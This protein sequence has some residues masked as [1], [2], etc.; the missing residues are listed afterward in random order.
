MHRLILSTLVAGTLLAVHMPAA[1]QQN[2]FAGGERY[3]KTG[4]AVVKVTGSFEFDEEIALTTAPS[5]TAADD[6]MTWIVYGDE[7]SGEPFVIFT[8]GEYGYGITVGKGGRTATAEFD[9]C[10]GKVDVTAGTVVGDYTC[11][12]VESMDRDFRAL[13]VSISIHFTAGS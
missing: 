3:Y 12:E 7:T 11:P 9:M 13:E 8:Y 4:S 2:P 5:Y 1:G 6:G 10:E